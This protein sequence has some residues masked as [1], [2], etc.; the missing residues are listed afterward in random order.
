M[1]ASFAAD[2]I[3][4]VDAQLAMEIQAKA[5]V[6]LELSPTIAEV[7][8]ILKREELDHHVQDS[9]AS[10]ATSAITFDVAYTVH[11]HAC[12]GTALTSRVV[13]I[14]IVGGLVRQK[15]V[16]AV[17]PHELNCMRSGGDSGLGPVR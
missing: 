5:N 11:K 15:G 16:L 4:R 7:V 3:T 12:P 6:Q 2:A 8:L 17:P 14:I 13:T 1:K 9:S 10:S